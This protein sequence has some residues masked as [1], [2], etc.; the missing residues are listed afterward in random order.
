MTLSM[1]EISVKKVLGKVT[2]K[3]D[4]AFGEMVDQLSGGGSQSTP[5]NTAANE[6]TR[7]ITQAIITYAVNDRLSV[8]AG[9]FYTPVGFEVVKAKDNWQY[10]R[11]YLFN[12]GIPFWHEGLS[13]NYA[14]IPKDFFATLYVLNSW[15]G[16]ISQEQNESTTLGLNLNYTGFE[17]LSLNYNYIGGAEANNTG[18]REVHELNGTYQINEKYALGLDAILGSQKEVASLGDVRWSAY[19]IYFKAAVNDIYAISPRFEVFDDSDQGFAISGGLSAAGVKQKITSW[20]LTNSFNLGQGLESRIEIRHDQSDS[21][22]Y[23][24]KSDGSATDV[25]QTYTFALLYSL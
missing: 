22:L 20:T 21:D 17:N 24:K 15:D 7:N 23:F 4:L 3:T 11:G 12:Y 6:P 16:R 5:I 13:V 2:L 19:A 14:I 1:A 18:L 8:N 25:Q 10:S 9:K